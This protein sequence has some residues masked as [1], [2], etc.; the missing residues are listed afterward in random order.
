MQHNLTLHEVKEFE[1]VAGNI[2]VVEYSVEVVQQPLRMEEGHGF[3][4]FQDTDYNIV[5]NYA[6][7]EYD[8]DVLDQL[9]S[10]NIKYI[11]DQIVKRLNY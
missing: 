5:I 11:N 9:D 4:Y 2:L 6:R 8:H 10:E 7:D 1:D 3:H